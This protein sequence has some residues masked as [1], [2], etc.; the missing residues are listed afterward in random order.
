MFR[1]RCIAENHGRY[2]KACQ[3]IVHAL[4]NEPWFPEVEYDYDLYGRL[5]TD[6][7]MLCFCL[8]T[9]FY[10]VYLCMKQV[11]CGVLIISSPKIVNIFMQN[12][13]FLLDNWHTMIYIYSVVSI[14]GDQTR[15]E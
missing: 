6:D 13:I 12:L 14:M 9:S 11:T 8:S 3:K 10:V 1:D 2:S 5:L 15:S 7:N 4:L